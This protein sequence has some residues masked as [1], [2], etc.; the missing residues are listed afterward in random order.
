MSEG[1]S[2]LIAMGRRGGTLGKP[3]ARAA[4]VDPQNVWLPL[5]TI[6]G[7]VLV[8]S[9]I[10]I[11]TIIQAGISNMQF[12]HSVGPTVLCGAAAITGNTV[13]TIYTITG[14]V[15]D[16][17]QIGLGGIPIPGGL[18]GG[19]LATGINMHGYIMGPGTIDVTMTAVAGTGSTR[20]FVHYV[21]YEGSI[22]ST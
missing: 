14:N 12:R 17:L 9:L 6:T 1:F 18:A 10:G 19:L 20:Y 16:A 21:P 15:A 4:A 8:T 2:K 7:Y 5:F 13:G 3:V 22:V 11:R